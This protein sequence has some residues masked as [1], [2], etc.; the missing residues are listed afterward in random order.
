MLF[1]RVF[2]FL[3]LALEWMDDTT[4]GNGLLANVSAVSQT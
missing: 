2:S 1:Y 4:I 3:Y